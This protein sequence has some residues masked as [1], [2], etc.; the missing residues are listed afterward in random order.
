M[1]ILKVKFNRR[2]IRSFGDPEIKI[3]YLGVMLR[4]EEYNVVAASEIGELVERS[5]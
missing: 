3:S 5:K 4:L 2:S 1:Q